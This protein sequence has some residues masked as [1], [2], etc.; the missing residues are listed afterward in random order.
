[1]KTNSLRLRHFLGLAAVGATILFAP[2]RAAT[3]ITLDPVSQNIA[4]GG[5]ALVNLNVSGLG[6]A[7]VTPSLGGWLAHIAFNNSII[8]INSVTF[9]TNLD[10]GI[11]GVIQGVDATTAGLLQIDEVSF[12]D[13]AALNAAQPSAF[14]LATLK[15]TGLTAGTS[16]LTFSRLELSDELGFPMA[17]SM[18][19]ASI[20]VGGGTGVPDAGATTLAGV[21][22][23]ALLCLIDA[24][25]RR[26]ATK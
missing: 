5:T 25:R 22:C 4:V 6:A 21:L 12:E 10:L 2:A 18:S 1:M 8:S 3:S 9:G 19:T 26:I 20:T 23:V 17:T 16:T 11:F 13:I 14:T 15:F 7:G 24:R